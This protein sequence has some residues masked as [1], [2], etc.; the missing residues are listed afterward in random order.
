MDVLVPIDGSA[1]SIHA[2]E[3]A[4]EFARRFDASLDVVHFS[5]AETEATDEIRD[6]ATDRLPD[7]IDATVRII[8]D[9]GLDFRPAEH[10]GRAI[11]SIVDERDIDHVI[12]GH[13]GSG[14]VDRAILGHP[15][16]IFVP[17]E[18]IRP[19]V[20]VLGHDQ[21]HR[22]DQLRDELDRRGIDCEVRRASPRDPRDGELLSSQ[23][24][25]EAI[26][27]RRAD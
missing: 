13:H 23:R 20:I 17:I 8:V 14:T 3:F 6:R 11:L 26:V 15:E 9:D 12:M 10:I 27:E 22:E 5:D 2:L 19:A 7:D 24:I 25:I 21:H 18:R 4:A 1:C 16:D